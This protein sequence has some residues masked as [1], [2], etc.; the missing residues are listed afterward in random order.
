MSRFAASL[1][2]VVASPF[3]EVGRGMRMEGWGIL[4]L[5]AEQLWGCPLKGAAPSQRAIFSLNRS[6]EFPGAL[7]G[8]ANKI[9]Q[10]EEPV[11]LLS[12]EVSCKS[13]G[14][15]HQSVYF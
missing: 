8:S 1:Q 9:I 12:P 15:G 10:S 13:R 4:R 7:A 2:T 6:G 14:L 11:S 3:K 5:G